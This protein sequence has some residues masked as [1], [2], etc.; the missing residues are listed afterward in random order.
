MSSAP[1]PVRFVLKVASPAENSKV[2]KRHQRPKHTQQQQQPAAKASHN[3]QENRHFFHFSERTNTQRQCYLP[4]HSRSAFFLPFL[5]MP[6]KGAVC[7]PVFLGGGSVAGQ[8]PEIHPDPFEKVQAVNILRF[9]DGYVSDSLC[10]HE[11]VSYST[12]EWLCHPRQTQKQG[13]EH[14]RTESLKSHNRRQKPKKKQETLWREN[15]RNVKEKCGE[16]SALGRAQ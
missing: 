16:A 8:F 10:R 12:V 2:G 7:D 11:T 14:S 9:A 15:A 5:C 3:K 13:Y 1:W 6:K 4:A